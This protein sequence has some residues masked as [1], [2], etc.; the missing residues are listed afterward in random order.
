M[1]TLN[2][3]ESAEKLLS[4]KVDEFKKNGLNNY[5]GN[6]HSQL[7]VVQLHKGNYDQALFFYN[8]A[9]KYDQDAGY[10]SFNC[11][12]TLKDIGYNIYFKHFNNNDKAL[13]YYKK[14]LS[15]VNKDKNQNVADR[16]ES[17]D[18]F[19]HIAN[20]FVAKGLFDSARSIFN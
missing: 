20:G 6:A 4:K 9:F 15:Y 12:Q 7:A 18:I 19:T 17:L 3:Y 2:Q 13:F 10:G 1:I 5:L 16:F 8:Q 14:A 11:K